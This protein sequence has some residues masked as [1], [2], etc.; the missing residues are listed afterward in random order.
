M[1]CVC[2]KAIWH[3]A[4]WSCQLQSHQTE[5]DSR[6]EKKRWPSCCGSISDGNNKRRDHI[7]IL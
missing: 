3:R 2:T 4:S 7:S 6:E 5:S 1:T